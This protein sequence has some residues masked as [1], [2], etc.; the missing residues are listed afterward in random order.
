[1]EVAI[2]YA[3]AI[4][5][6]CID[7]VASL[8]EKFQE[9]PGK[10]E[11]MDVAMTDFNGRLLALEER[12]VTLEEESLKLHKA[13]EARVRELELQ[14]VL[15]QAKIQGLVN[16]RQD[17]LWMINS[18]CNTIT[19]MEGQL[20]RM[21]GQLME[22]ESWRAWRDIPFHQAPGPPQL[23]PIEGPEEE[24]ELSPVV[25]D[26]SAEERAQIWEDKASG[27]FDHLVEADHVARDLPPLFQDLPPPW[28][29]RR[30]GWVD[31]WMERSGGWGPGTDDL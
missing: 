20:T 4:G 19:R 30:I 6:S 10:V 22:L 18:F 28:S 7:K 24:W 9:L 29:P 26:Y 16:G 23:V 11:M 14:L 2:G 1:M 25:R 13:L 31:K 21:E 27:H 15:E 12:E 3:G 5:V 8:N 17:Q